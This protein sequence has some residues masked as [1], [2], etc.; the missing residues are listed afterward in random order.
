[1]IW[2]IFSNL[3]FSIAF[4]AFIVFVDLLVKF[5]N[6]RD[7]KFY[8]LFLTFSV[9]MVGLINALFAVDYVFYVAVFKSAMV[10]SFLNILAIL[11]FPKYKNWS[12]GLSIY[13]FQQDRV[14]LL[15]MLFQLQL[16][17]GHSLQL[18]RMRLQLGII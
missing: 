13:I 16:A 3:Y 6:A 15:A 1:M 7:L 18:H 9:G 2:S 17:N 11:Y 12:L 4:V 14:A 8:F 5:E 10:F